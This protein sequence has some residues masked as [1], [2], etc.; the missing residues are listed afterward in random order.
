MK[1]WFRASWHGRWLC[2]AECRINHSLDC[3][4]NLVLPWQSTLKLMH[5]RRNVFHNSEWLHSAANQMTLSFAVKT[6]N[7][8]S[9]IRP[10]PGLQ[11]GQGTLH[12]CLLE[13]ENPRKPMRSVHVRHLIVPVEAVVLGEAGQWCLPLIVSYWELFCLSPQSVIFYSRY[14]TSDKTR[15]SFSWKKMD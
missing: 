15:I 13:P 9:A 7:T 2:M 12:L 5:R 10:S 3:S 4:L 11:G 1:G 14:T 8:G 6:M